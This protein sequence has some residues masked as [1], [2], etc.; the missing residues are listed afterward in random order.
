MGKASRGNGTEHS[1]VEGGG[2]VRHR[3]TAAV[4]GGLACLTGCAMT[5]E[6]RVSNEIFWEAAKE[7]EFRYR[8][9]H[10]DRIDPDGNAS[11]HADADSRQ[12]LPAFIGCYRQGVRTRIEQRRQ[13]GLPVPDTL[14]RE[15]DADID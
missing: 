13:A 1:R 14:N 8:T 10:L 12:E 5:P 3:W 11:M 7:C 6:A 2:G 9:L 15:P 4:I